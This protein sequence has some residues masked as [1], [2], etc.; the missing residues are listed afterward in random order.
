MV[1]DGAS[2][3]GSAKPS[4]VGAHMA[5]S[6]HPPSNYRRSVVRRYSVLLLAAAIVP[7]L[8]VAALYD[9][10]ARSLVARF[11]GEQLDAQLAASASRLGSFLDERRYQLDALARYPARPGRAGGAVP[12]GEVGSLLRI[13]ADG[14]DVYGVLFFSERGKLE[15][16]V[17]GQA[18][19][20]PPYWLELPFDPLAL[21]RRPLREAD[22]VGP[23]PPTPGQSGWFL[24]REA[25]QGGGTVALHVRLASLT[26][27]LGPPTAAGVLEP[28]LRTPNGDFDAVGRPVA[29]QG[30]LLEGPE[31]AAGWRPGLL[32]D[33]DE[34]LRPFRAARYALV[35]ASI[36]AL[37]A[38]AWVTARLAGR[39][40][41]RVDLLAHGA[42]VVSAGDFTHRVADASDDELGFLA[43][44]FNR[45][46]SR[47]GGLVERT[48][49]MGRLAAL[50]EFSTGVA[51]EVRNP[52]ATL[53]TTV[54]ALAR[55]EKEPQRHAL[56]LD[57]GREIDRMARA[58]EDLLAFG[59][60]R[61]PSRREVRLGETL[62]SLEAMVAP[63][64]RKR[65]VAFALAGDL[66]LAVVV[67]PDHLQQ[68][69]MNLV[70]NALHATPAGGRVT[71]SARLEGRRVIV[72]I[73]D[74][75]TGLSEEQLQHAF[76]PFFTTKAGG[77]GLGLS[78]SRQLA[79][80]N[81]GGLAL[82]S[83]A[84]KGTTARLAL[85]RQGSDDDE[86]PHHR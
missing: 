25:L 34:L 28:I 16:A 2:R 56:L 80:L 9:L 45:M 8:L 79:E 12:G 31:I 17:A 78:I 71:A 22:L 23:A 62:R 36:V 40:K 1:D 19:S 55:V 68:I 5:V 20:G 50:G 6:T 74:T 52:L 69:L 64:A 65:Q 10:Y 86:R 63:E 66:D 46:A 43:I 72:E 33:S 49:R 29:I 85:A 14:P 75:G 48:V 37:A 18:A 15:R 7:L 57:M 32:V 39:L 84:G 38:I 73:A 4:P 26:E 51:H 70:L 41:H 58:M 53:K 21:P 61:P 11:T 3:A 30:R 77:T 27:L 60:P 42:E 54:Q 76:E 13:A 82:E 83:A 47:L 81:G 44:S 59:R 24:V 67:D 35:I